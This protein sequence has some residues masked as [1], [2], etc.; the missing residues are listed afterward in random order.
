MA[1]EAFFF[2][3]YFCHNTHKMVFLCGPSS[4]AGVRPGSEGSTPCCEGV[5][6]CAEGREDSHLAET[7]TCLEGA[8]VIAH[9]FWGREKPIWTSSPSVFPCDLRTFKIIT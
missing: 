9:C 7:D 5:S 2:F 1:F 3:L 8:S 6:V 4:K